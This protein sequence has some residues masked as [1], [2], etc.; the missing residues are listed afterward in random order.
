MELP[1]FGALRTLRRLFQLAGFLA[2][3]LAYGVISGDAYFFI[4]NARLRRQFLTRIA[5]RFGQ[6]FLRLFNVRV[7]Y[8]V[9][10]TSFPGAPR[11]IVANHVSTLDILILAALEPMVFITSTDLGEQTALGTLAQLGGSVFVNRRHFFNLKAE[12]SEVQ[13][14]FRQGHTIVLFAEGTSCNGD[15]IFPFKN[16][17]FTV[18]IATES[19]VQPVCFNYRFLD[20]EPITPANRDTLF[21]YGDMGFWSHLWRLCGVRSIEVDCDFLDPIPTTSQDSRK[22]VSWV[23]R[24]AIANQF[25]GFCPPVE[26]PE[27]APPNRTPGVMAL[28]H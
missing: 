13:F 27:A 16:A 12:I 5:S 7:R 22:V 9:S 20:G 14:L 26:P 19:S 24:Q 10:P 1:L 8:R 18:P 3:V 23:T 25:N 15:T 11:F 4:P 2:R 28:S 6:S 17:F 21:F